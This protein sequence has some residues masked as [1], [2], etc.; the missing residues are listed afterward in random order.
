MSDEV[1]EV[2][3][4]RRREL[5]RADGTIELGAAAVAA[6][7]VTLP[8]SLRVVATFLI[9]F[10]FLKS[11]CVGRARAHVRAPREVAL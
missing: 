4:R 1:V 11:G 2:T 3:V 7:A 10:S 6:P 8:P 5:E 9:G